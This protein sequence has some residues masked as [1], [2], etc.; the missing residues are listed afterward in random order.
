MP[1]PKLPFRE[2]INCPDNTSTARFS[3]DK[4][5]PGKREFAGISGDFRFVEA[6]R[7]HQKMK[8]RGKRD[9][10]ARTFVARLRLTIQTY[11]PEEPHQ[12]FVARGSALVS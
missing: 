7:T 6:E 9:S 5:V 3:T 2:N 8:W 1:G 10:N 4:S 12:T 11:R